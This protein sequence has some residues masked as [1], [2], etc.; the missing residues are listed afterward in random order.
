MIQLITITLIILALIF[1]VF[2]KDLIYD[3]RKVPKDIQFAS[4]FIIFLL[5]IM[6]LISPVLT[7]T[8]DVAPK[9]K[10]IT[11]Q[12]TIINQYVISDSD[13][14]LVSQKSKIDTIST[15]I[16]PDSLHLKKSAEYTLLGVKSNVKIKK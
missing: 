2:F 16:L 14:L 12:K 1:F 7:K 8:Y 3:K 6:W 15:G 10:T 13:T 4:G 9:S 11:I 5:L